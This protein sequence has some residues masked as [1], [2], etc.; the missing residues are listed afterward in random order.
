[1]TLNELLSLLGRELSHTDIGNAEITAND[2]RIP[3]ATYSINGILFIP[4]LLNDP[5]QIIL[6]LQP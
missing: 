4:G 6:R 5:P 3:E 1:M 2:P